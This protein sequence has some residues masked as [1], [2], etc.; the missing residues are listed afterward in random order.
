MEPKQC[1]ASQPVLVWC[2]VPIVLYHSKQQT[3]Q[4]TLYKLLYLL[5]PASLNV[6]RSSMGRLQLSSR[7]NSAST[8]SSSSSITK[9]GDDHF[10]YR[11]NRSW[12]SAS[13]SKTLRTMIVL[14]M[15]VSCTLFYVVPSLLLSSSSDEYLENPYGA[16]GEMNRCGCRCIYLYIA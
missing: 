2:M 12:H 11:V 10:H 7:H 16:K 6:V 13:A 1:L 5:C 8:S 4:Q 15:L 14:V 3:P 9:D